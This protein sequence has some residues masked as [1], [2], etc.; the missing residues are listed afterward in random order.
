MKEFVSIAVFRDY[1]YP[2]SVVGWAPIK[3]EPETFFIE[4]QLQYA[5]EAI[6][7]EI[8]QRIRLDGTI[9]RRSIVKLAA[10]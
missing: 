2:S 4:R 9:T 3:S 7:D 1:Q 6:T 10:W 5:L 8:V